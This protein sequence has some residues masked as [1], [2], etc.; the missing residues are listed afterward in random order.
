MEMSAFYQ[1]IAGKITVP[2]K[3]LTIVRN[4]DGF[5]SDSA[6]QRA[7]TTQTG[8]LFVAGSPLA[9]RIHFE[10]QYK[11]AP[12]TRFCYICERPELLLPDIQA[13]AHVTSFAVTDLF[14]N[15]QDR[16]TLLAQKPDVLESLY[17]KNIPG[18]V[19]ATDLSRHLLEIEFAAHAKPTPV[20]DP[21]ADMAAIDP[22][23][24]ILTPTVEAVSQSIL[25]AIRQDKYDLIRPELARLNDRFQEY[26][27]LAYFATLHA[28][29]FLAPRSVNK[30]LPF[31][32][33][34][35]RENERVVLLVVDGMAWW[36]YLVLREQLKAEKI[37]TSDDTIF[38]WVP[39]ITMLSRQAIFRGDDPVL[40]YK[41]NPASEEKLWNAWW[42]AQGIPSADIQYIYGDSEPEVWS[43]TRR[44]ALVSV[45]L[46]EVMHISDAPDL[47]LACTEA[48]ARRFARTIIALKDQGFAIYITT[49]HGNVLSTGEAPLTSAEKTHLFQD[50]SRGARHLIYEAEAPML[51]F[52]SNHAPESFLV[53]DNWLAYRGEQ[54]FNKAGKRQITHGG[55]HLLEVAIPF[56]KVQ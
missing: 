28:S 3:R 42:T 16:K 54:A 45:T 12:D 46:D 26:L 51:E 24:S 10:L 21:V 52:L 40:D 25:T 41:Q 2:Y 4:L 6:V 38:A 13:E 1:D 22:K 20:S 33:F 55:S 15:I 32:T 56:I 19:T 53:H 43:T 36:Q 39:T 17:A 34:N 49:D 7:L 18:F 29:H 50:G 8:I 14:P 27:D 47:L 37:R 5:L 31:L 48:W 30:I 11:A 23:W 44:L 35:H 9:L